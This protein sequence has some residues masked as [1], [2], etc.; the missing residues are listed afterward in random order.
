MEEC[1]LTAIHDQNF[2]N[3]FFRE[4]FLMVSTI[5]FLFFKLGTLTMNKM[6]IQAETP[7]YG[8]NETQYSLLRYAAMAAKWKGII[9]SLIFI[10]NCKTRH[11]IYIYFVITQ[12]SY[13]WR[14]VI[15]LHYSLISIFAA[16][17]LF[18][19]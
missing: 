7:I 3:L 4:L 8:D 1:T 15:I 5:Y 19:F 13:Y 14:M 16:L 6:V 10:L 17:P 11:I 12:Y 9:L 18:I 2:F